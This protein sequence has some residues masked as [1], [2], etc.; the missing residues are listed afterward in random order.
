KSRLRGCSASR[1]IRRFPRLACQQP[2][3]RGIRQIILMAYP[4]K[5]ILDEDNTYGISL[6]IILIAHPLIKTILDK[7]NTYGI[8]LKIILDKD[9]T[10]STSS[11]GKYYNI[12]Y[13]LLFSSLLFYPIIFSMSAFIL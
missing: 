4:L 3:K 6:K 13:P 9:N 2:Q 7:D 11:E 12:S 1:G 10:Y 8:S 5:I